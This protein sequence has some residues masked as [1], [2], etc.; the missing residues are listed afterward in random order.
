[1]T[2]W[3]CVD[4]AGRVRRAAY[5]HGSA[6][7][8]NST[9]VDLGDRRLVLVSP[10]GGEAAAG[11]LDT[12][13]TLGEVVAVVAPNGYHRMGLPG[14]AGRYPRAGLYAPEGA[15]ARVR[16]VLD[17]AVPLRPLGELPRAEGVEIFV[18][19]HMKAPDTVLRVHTEV[20]WVWSL[21]DV[22][23][24]LDVVSSNPVE[25]WVLGLL[26]YQLGLR[27]NRTGCRFAFLAD[28]AAYADWLLG[29][30]GRLPPALFSPGHGPV[31]RTPELLG[32]LPVLAEEIRAL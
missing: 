2:T 7:T 9:A 26:G 24:N 8:A 18:P 19:P 17:P 22:V 20:G 31:L 21:T 10:P 25:R 11:L 3:E 12:L 23:I 27:V 30:L 15:M 29:E 28:K 5:H 13:D 1:M 14:A 32:R 4:P 16:K 6:G